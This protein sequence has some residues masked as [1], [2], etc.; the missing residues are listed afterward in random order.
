MNIFDYADRMD[1]DIVVRRYSRQNNRWMC[2]FDGVEVCQN[3]GM[4]LGAAGNGISPEAAITDYIKRIS[5][6]RI[7]NNGGSYTDVPILD[8]KPDNLRWREDRNF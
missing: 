3:G 5:G 8:Q 2:L 4:L 1:L 7:K 6:N